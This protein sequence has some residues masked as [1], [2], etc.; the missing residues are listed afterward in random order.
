MK[1]ES[2]QAPSIRSF[3]V[4]GTVV[5]LKVYGKYGEIAI[6]KAIDRLNDIDNKMSV[7]KNFSEVSRINKEAGVSS[8]K[9]SKDTYFIIQK[10]IK[11]SGLSQGNFDITIKPIV[12]LWGIGTDTARI[13]HK[14]EI[15]RNLK[16]VNY[17]DIILNEE[18]SSIGLKYKGQ[19]IDVG[20]IAK[21]YAADEVRSI[22]KYYN[23]RSALINL[24][25]NLFALGK[26]LDEDLWNI[27]IQDPFKTRGEYVGLISAKNKSIV[28]SG[29]Y[30]RYFEDKGRVFHHIIDPKTGYPS[31]SEII[32]AT[33]IS[34]NSMD[35]DGLSTGVYIM[36]INKSIN[37][38]ESLEGIDAV[39]ITKNKE[40]YVTSG[41][42]D[43]FKITNK[44]FTYKVNMK[45]K[46]KF[47][48][49]NFRI[50]AIKC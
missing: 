44:G 13:P 27:G 26:K 45:S 29:N 41:I 35:G 47:K 16:L 28:T 42:R 25:G 19:K 33:I 3:Y 21:G 5:Q 2:N 7:F 15:A 30:E 24:G 37:L 14:D 18:C 23:V 12:S 32:S 40:I 46:L 1:I 31:E 10:A 4:L 43:K 6:D 36:G 20:G 11:Y 50:G 9:V 49:G 8:Q 22:L 39:F 17:K 38:I 48:L 34:S